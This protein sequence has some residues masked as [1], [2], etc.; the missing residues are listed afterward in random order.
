ALAKLESMTER[1][2]PEHKRELANEWH[3]LT[4][5]DHVVRI[6]RMKKFSVL[7]RIFLMHFYWNRVPRSGNFKPE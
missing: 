4:R 2:K 7:R 3:E 1:M 5:Q 6:I